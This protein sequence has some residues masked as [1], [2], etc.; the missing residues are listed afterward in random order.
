ML[1]GVVLCSSACSFSELNT[2]WATQ[3][4][5]AEKPMQ[6]SQEQRGTGRRKSHYHLFEV[7]E[8][9]ICGTSL[10]SERQDLGLV[11]FHCAA[12]NAAP[13][14][15]GKILP[16]FLQRRGSPAPDSVKLGIFSLG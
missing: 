3:R 4:S 12:A 10:S 2:A 7:K 8:R 9:R 6:G 15:T 5:Y 13:T 11:D 1:V 14:V 16:S